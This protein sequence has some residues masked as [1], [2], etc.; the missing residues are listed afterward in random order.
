MFTTTLFDLRVLTPTP[1]P[2]LTEHLTILIDCNDHETGRFNGNIVS[3][4]VWRNNEKILALWDERAGFYDDTTCVRFKANKVHFWEE[5]PG[6]SV[7][8]LSHSK[9]DHAPCWEAFTI[10]AQHLLTLLNWFAHNGHFS[11]E[12]GPEA[13]ETKWEECLSDESQSARFHERDLSAL[14]SAIP[15]L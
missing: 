11:W 6:V 4:E 5:I 12:S 1:N 8:I 10:E 9:S 14:L 13:L 2:I 15:K 7:P 3:F